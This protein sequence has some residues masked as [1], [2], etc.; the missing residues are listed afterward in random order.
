MSLSSACRTLARD[1]R[2]R[3]SIRNF[4]GT[5]FV[6]RSRCIHFNSCRYFSAAKY[7]VDRNRISEIEKLDKQLILLVDTDQ[8]S[9][10]HR[11]YMRRF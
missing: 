5:H 8:A 3:N 4:F 10:I 11:I 6:A 7:G 1:A 9:L 2:A